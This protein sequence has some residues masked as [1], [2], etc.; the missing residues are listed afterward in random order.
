[1]IRLIRG[2]VRI[3]TRSDDAK[4]EK[5]GNDSG[6]LGHVVARGS[7]H[8]LFLRFDWRQLNDSRIGTRS[9]VVY[10]V[11][12]DNHGSRAPDSVDHDLDDSGGPMGS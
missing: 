8:S 7:N 1:M 9:Y 11:A 4:V 3:M 10:L 2:L 6:A 5:A 12:H